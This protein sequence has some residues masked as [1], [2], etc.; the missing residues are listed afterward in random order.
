LGYQLKIFAICAGL[1]IIL[2][3]GSAASYEFGSK[4][5][6]GDVDV[7]D[8]L[9]NSPLNVYWLDT[10]SVLGFDPSDVA[11]LHQGLGTNVLP[12]DIRLTPFMGHPAG[13]RV[14]IGDVDMNMQILSFAGGWS[15]SELFIPNGICDIDEP[16]YY[17]SSP[18]TNLAVMALRL[19][20][21]QG[22][23]PGSWVKDS[24][25]DF[26]NPTNKLLTATLCFH[27]QGATGFYD[28]SDPVYLKIDTT[29]PTAVEPGDLRLVALN[30][31]N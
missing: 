28:D 17:Q 10:Q 11:Y 14:K 2:A 9:A 31:E 23:N 30:G 21:L 8:S 22:L 7:G 19:S 18:G 26:N 29:N 27:D 3:I 20:K 4:V 6:N 5:R 1:M 12:N 24:D 25:S 16:V 15:Y 13:S